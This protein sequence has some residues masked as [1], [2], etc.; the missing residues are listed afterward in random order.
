[1]DCGRYYVGH[2]AFSV[3][4]ASHVSL[5]TRSYFFLPEISEE[6]RKFPNSSSASSVAQENFWEHSIYVYL[7]V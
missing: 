6:D 4:R 1:M 3:M 2:F 7:F 5:H